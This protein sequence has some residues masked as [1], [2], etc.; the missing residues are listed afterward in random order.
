MNIRTITPW[1]GAPLLGIFS[2]LAASIATPA[3]AETPPAPE[4]NRETIQRAFDAWAAGNGSPFDLLAEDARWTITGNSVAA[5]TYPNREAFLR[6]VIR[7]FNARMQ[8]G[9]KPRIRSLH[10]DGDTVIVFFDARGTARDGKPYLNTYAWFLDM[11][12]GRIIRASAFF[13]S[14][15]FN[16]LWSRVPATAE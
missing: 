4:R 12:A 7:P 15:E 13:D 14:I 8:Q 5:K 6:E 1:L 2:M 9:L 11:R 16:D 10:A 3:N